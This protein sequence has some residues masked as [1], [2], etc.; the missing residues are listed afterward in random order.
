MEYITNNLGYIQVTKANQDSV[1]FAKTS[2][3][4]VILTNGAVYLE[5]IDD[6]PHFLNYAITENPAS[7]GTVYSTPSLLYYDILNYLYT[8]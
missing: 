1:S 4:K 2:I 6:I 5:L 3:K 7:P 8:T